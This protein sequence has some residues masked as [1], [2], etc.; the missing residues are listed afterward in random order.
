MVHDLCTQSTSL[1]IHDSTH[2]HWLITNEVGVANSPGSRGLHG[3]GQEADIVVVLCHHVPLHRDVQFVPQ[4]HLPLVVSAP[5]SR[6]RE[7]VVN[8]RFQVLQHLHVGADASLAI[9]LCLHKFNCMG[10]PFSVS[11]HHTSFLCIILYIHVYL[12]V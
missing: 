12:S 10:H 8:T 4:F 1:H 7:E 3:L 9:I 6:L 5:D 11:L 2:T